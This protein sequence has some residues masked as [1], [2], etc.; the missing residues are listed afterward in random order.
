MSSIIMPVERGSSTALLVSAHVGDIAVQALYDPSLAT[1]LVADSFIRTNLFRCRN[2]SI[3][4]FVSLQTT[5]GFFTCKVPFERASDMVHDV[6]LGCD[7][8]S[9]A[10]ETVPGVDIPL[11]HGGRNLS[12]YPSPPSSLT[13]TDPSF[14]PSVPMASAIPLSDDTGP[15]ASGSNITG[16]QAQV[17]SAQEQVSNTPPPSQAFS[18]S[19]IIQNIERVTKPIAFAMASQHGLLHGVNKRTTVDVLRSAIVWHISEGGC[20]KTLN[21]EGCAAFLDKHDESS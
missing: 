12:P 2:G 1:S 20:S 19:Y 10:M 14:P 4:L 9:Y 15:Q 6:I 3:R 13:A 11:V 21:L 8:Y 17:P 5:T 18:L 16:Y 7:W